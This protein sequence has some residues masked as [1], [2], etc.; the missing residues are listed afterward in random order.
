MTNQPLVLKDSAGQIA[1]R[2]TVILGLLG[3][4]HDG[5][6]GGLT[7]RQKHALGELLA[8]SEELRLLL[9]PLLQERETAP[10]ISR[11]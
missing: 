7:E 11:P 6:F 8:T 4:L 3:L 9:R 1:D 5:A 10:P 2:L